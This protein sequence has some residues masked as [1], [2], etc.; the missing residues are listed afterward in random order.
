MLKS[1]TIILILITVF[2]HAEYKSPSY[3]EYH[4]KINQAENLIAKKDFQ[5]ALQLYE[6]VFR[7]YSFV[8]L[9]DIEVACQLAFYLQLDDLAFQ[10]I[11][12]GIRH[13][14][15]LKDVK[16]NKF[17]SPLLKKPEWKIIKEKYPELRQG[18]MDKQDLV[19]RE[20]AQEMFKK[21]QKMA[22]G[23]LFKIGNKA[24][25][26]YGDEKFAP[27]SEQ[28]MAELLDILEVY[29]YPGEQLI[30]N[31]Y[32]I[33]TVLSHHNSISSDY[34]QTDTLYETI[35]PLLKTAV[36]KGE[37]SPYEFALIEDWK[38]AVQSNRKSPGYGYLIP[39]TANTLSKTNEFREAIG[40]R[41][42]ELRNKLVDI[43]E[44][45][46]MNFLLP[47]WVSGKITIE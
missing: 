20:R 5:Q 19:L 36:S 25:E 13:G 14:W 40:L 7:S 11:E 1:S 39:P 6:E 2:V 29:G 28:Q 22:M 4:F 32:W 8:F 31:D 37:M 33:S 35:R 10:L 26:K 12:R 21:D 45:T 15:E 46:G 18:Y 3:K 38:I 42:V 41:S 23:A 34:V 9:R 44:S 17:I 30:G 16:K 27:H 24:Q 43:E 47:D